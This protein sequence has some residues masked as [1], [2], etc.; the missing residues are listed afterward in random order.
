MCL[1]WPRHDFGAMVIL[2]GGSMCFR[3]LAC[4]HVLHVYIRPGVSR[5]IPCMHTW[6]HACQ[7]FPMC[8]AL[9]SLCHVD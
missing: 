9:G 5:H 6:L 1:A 4:F 3:V 7:L 2:G 8:D